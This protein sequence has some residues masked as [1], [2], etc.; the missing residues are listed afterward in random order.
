MLAVVYKWGVALA[1]AGI[2]VAGGILFDELVAGCFCLFDRTALDDP[3]VKSLAELLLFSANLISLSR[4]FLVFDLTLSV[5]LSSIVADRLFPTDLGLVPFIFTPFMGDECS[6]CIGL[7]FLSS[8]LLSN[9]KAL[10]ELSIFPIRIVSLVP[11]SATADSEDS[12]DVEDSFD[13]EEEAD[14]R[15]ETLDE[16]DELKSLATERSECDPAASTGCRNEWK[17]KR[18]PFANEPPRWLLM[19]LW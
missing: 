15:V 6:F 10:S 19:L 17:P 9:D 13:E 8:G 11:T 3:L 12:A 2:V 5:S 14:D 1:C 16:T 7:R 18:P 4:S